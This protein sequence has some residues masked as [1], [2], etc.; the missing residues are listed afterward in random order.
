MKFRSTPGLRR[1]ILT[2]IVFIFVG[3]STKSDNPRGQTCRLM[4]RKQS[5]MV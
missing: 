4:F 3:Q 1:W 2:N 5:G